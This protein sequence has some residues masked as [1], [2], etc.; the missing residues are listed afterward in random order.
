MHATVQ[1]DFLTRDRLP[2]LC[3][4]VAFILTFFVTRLVVRYIRR[5]A[6]D[7]RPPKWWQPR[8]MGHGSVHIHHMVIGVVLVMV[9]GVTMVTLA[10]NGGVAEFTVA[11]VF[12]GI[13]AALVLDEFAL[14]LHLSDVYW[15]QDGRTSVDAVFAAVAV[16]GLLILGF[17]PLSFFDIGIWREDQSPVGR[18]VVVAVAV[19]TLLLAV[20]VLLKGKVWTGLVG[21]F[22]T[23]LLFVGAVR[24]SRP[25]A[26]WARWRYTGQP[27]RM[28][29][30]L[31]RER[32]LRRPVVQAKLWLQDAIT[33]MPKVPDDATVDA[34]L[35]RE[36]HAA[37]APGD[38]TRTAA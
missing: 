38:P 33:G 4:L 13:G 15:A 14:I 12:F 29:R 8:N 17:N 6:G 9:S 11:A 2:L 16:A 21:M 30:A 22:I 37:P 24:L 32:W 19:L 23:P 7:E 1:L 26:P 28:H 31:Q 5:N 18:A 34:Q 10:V 25:H 3:C 35:D 36:V 20:V 27:R